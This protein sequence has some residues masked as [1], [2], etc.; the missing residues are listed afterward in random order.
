MRHGGAALALLRYSA[1][2]PG[3]ILTAGAA[4][5]LGA[6]TISGVNPLN[7]EIRE[8]TAVHHLLTT[9]TTAVSPGDHLVGG[10]I[11]INADPAEYPFEII[12]N[13]TNMWDLVTTNNPKLDFE[14]TSRFTLQL[15]VRDQKGS[16]A[17]QTI[18]VK[19][20]DVNEPPVF[21]GT[22]ATQEYLQSVMKHHFI[23]HK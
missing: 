17:S 11:I 3:S 13:A 21:L 23:D 1:R 20:L 10:P 8:D 4:C 9:I 15:L 5:T 6:P 16:S 22:L 2:D 18:I 14:S 12:P 7:L 19:V